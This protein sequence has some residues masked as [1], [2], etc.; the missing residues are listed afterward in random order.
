MKTKLDSNPF[1]RGSVAFV[2]VAVAACSGHVADDDW[3]DQDS[4][5]LFGESSPNEHPLQ[6]YARDHVVPLVNLDNG[7]RCSGTQVREN[8]VV[9]AKHCVTQD[10]TIGGPLST[11]NKLLVGQRGIGAWP[12]ALV[13]GA[14]QRFLTFAECQ[15]ALN[16]NTVLTRNVFSP[17]D[18]AWLY[19]DPTEARNSIDG[20]LYVP[21]LAPS[22]RNV[23]ATSALAGYGLFRPA[24]PNDSENRLVH[25]GTVEITHFG[26]PNTVTGAPETR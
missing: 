25:Y 1:A 17:E 4:A 21:V 10:G 23:G 22:S 13:T 12:L 7:G 20:P 11:A 3:L 6:P 9:T 18:V 5:A 24:V 2:S 15:T 16:C 26:S 14:P 19:L 8:V